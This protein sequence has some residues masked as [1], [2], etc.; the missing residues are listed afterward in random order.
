MTRSLCDIPFLTSLG[1]VWDS[2]AGQ[3][4]FKGKCGE[5]TF[6]PSGRCT[7]LCGPL[8]LTTESE[9]RAALALFGVAC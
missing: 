3:L 7:W 4:T 8:E 2:N 1:G 9:V 6:T 5:L